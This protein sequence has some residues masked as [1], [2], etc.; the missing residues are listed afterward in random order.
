MSGA[1]LIV[2]LSLGRNPVS[3]RVRAAERDARAIAVALAIG[4]PV[5]GLHAGRPDDA[6]R[7]YL[8]MGL[9]ALRVVEIG[10]GADPIP[11][12]AAYLMQNA[13]ATILA[14]ARSEAGDGSGL[15]PYA[16]AGAL[17][18]P[19]APA[20]THMEIGP[21]E[22]RLMQALPGGR[23]RVLAARGPIVATVDLSG[24]PVPQ[25]ARG[26]A[27]RGAIEVVAPGPPGATV[28]LSPVVVADRPA[29]LRPKRIGP[30]AQGA[31]AGHRLLHQLPPREAARE[32]LRF[33][34]EERLIAPG[35]R[36]RLRELSEGLS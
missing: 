2:L 28:D 9:A 35:L 32:I 12:L 7:N 14:G 16:L 20:V 1:P 4:R 11:A 25:V 6:L 31:P 3:G 24:P 30:A 26:P 27:A 33:L 21:E 17:G 22:A 15:V 8:G 29:R 34:E 23:R 19:V 5:V 10:E 36:R 18:L 13:G